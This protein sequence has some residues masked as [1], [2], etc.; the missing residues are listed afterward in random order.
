MKK[1]LVLIL[2]F[3][4]AIVP[5]THSQSGVVVI[6]QYK[7]VASNPPLSATAQ[8]DYGSGDLPSAGAS[9]TGSIQW[10]VTPSPGDTLT[11]GSK[12]YTFV[13]AAPSSNEIVVAANFVTQGQAIT[14]R[15]NTDTASTLCTAVNNSDQGLGNG[16]VLLTANAQSSSG[17][18][19][20]LSVTI[21][22]GN[23]SV[24][25]FTGGV[26]AATLTVGGKTYTFVSG[27]AGAN[28]I[29][30]DNGFS[31]ICDDTAAIINTDTAT[32][33]CTAISDSNEFVDLTANT[34]GTAGNS[35]TLSTT[36]GTIALTS[37]HGG[38]D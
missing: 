37:F 4:L 33:L 11:V 25:P 22:L 9:A 6:H 30:V 13:V 21:T 26:D 10:T 35:I 20:P 18:S 34:P 38:T 23:L 15:I 5:V 2:L 29:S 3:A 12:T 27:T 14:D 16:L 19:I 1:Y 31:G 36:S 28:Q 17:N 32:T 8:I 7:A 24:T